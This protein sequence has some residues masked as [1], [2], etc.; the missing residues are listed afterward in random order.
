[1]TNQQF[2]A[3]AKL[4]R[5]RDSTSARAARAHFVDGLRPA[6]AARAVGCTPGAANAI[7]RRCRNA[8][9]LVWTVAGVADG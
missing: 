3:L 5:I 6:D 9:A 1:M 7:I 4:I 2:D 8:L